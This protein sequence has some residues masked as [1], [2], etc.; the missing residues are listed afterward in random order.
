LLIDDIVTDD[1]ILLVLM[2]LIKL[3]KPLSVKIVGMDGTNGSDLQIVNNQ[4]IL[5]RISDNLAF[6]FLTKSVYTTTIIN[7]RTNK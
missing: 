2:M 7:S 6:D 5:N 1:S 4:N 3:K